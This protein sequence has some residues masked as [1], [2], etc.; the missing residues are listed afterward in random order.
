MK[1][2]EL[3]AIDVHRSRMKRR[4][5][6]WTASDERDGRAARLEGKSIFDRH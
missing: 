4:S 1:L 6:L 3:I 2:D 5:L